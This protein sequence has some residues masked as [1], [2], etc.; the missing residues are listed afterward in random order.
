MSVLIVSPGKDPEAW[1]KA[2]ENRHPGMNIYVYPEEHDTEEVE[3]ALTW[4]H[5]RG[6]FKNYPNLKVIASMGAGVDHILSDNSLPE[7]VKVTKVVDETL[8]ED[9]GDFVLSQVMNHIRDLNY[10]SKAQTRKEWDQFQYKRPQNTTVGIM[11]LGVLGNAVAGK[12]TKNFFKVNAWSR[13]EKNCEDV[14][15]YHGK[16]QLEEFLN[17]SHVLVCLLPLTE[18]TENILNSDLFDM[19]PEGAF[20]INVARGEHLVE[21]DLMEMIDSGHL[22]GAS[23]DVFR[24]EPL[25]EEHPFWEHP[26]IHITPHIA[27]LTKPESVVDQIAENYD[28][29]KEDEPLK[30]K[31]ELDKGY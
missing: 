15:C 25:P 14:K 7:G 12:L 28:R 24:E 6:L 9:M 31:V 29:M 30:N 10:Y 13:T 2:L 19:L 22:S 18:D 11:G 26:K 3:F 16:D 17:N 5:P 1:V 8:T 27:S 20:V 23:L 21:H 4:N